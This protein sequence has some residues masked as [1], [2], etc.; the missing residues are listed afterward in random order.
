MIA[1][2]MLVFGGFLAS[3]RTRYLHLSWCGSTM[4]HRAKLRALAERRPS[5]HNGSENQAFDTAL[6]RLWFDCHVTGDKEF[7]FALEQIGT[8]R[9]VF[10][11]NFGGWDK[12]RCVMLMANGYFD[13]VDLLRLRKR[14]PHLLD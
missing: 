9:L 2:S 3:F 7:E 10:G 14:A 1:T 4:M 8:E 5:S 13:A 11:T 12:E 6:D